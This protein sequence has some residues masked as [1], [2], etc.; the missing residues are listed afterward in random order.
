MASAQNFNND[1]ESSRGFP[2]EVTGNMNF[3]LFDPGVGQSLLEDLARLESGHVKDSLLADAPLLNGYRL[4]PT[5][6]FAL[7]GVVTGHPRLPDGR[8]IVSSQLCYLD[9]ARGVARTLN[10][11]YRLGRPLHTD[12]H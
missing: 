5:A 6:A 1:F 10:R 11:F 7:E 4:V 8:M 9:A 3:C 2:Y 12:G